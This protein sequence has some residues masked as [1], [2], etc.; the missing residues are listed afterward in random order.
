[1]LLKLGVEGLGVALRNG[2]AERLFRKVSAF[3]KVA[4]NANAYHYGRA[5]VR[6]CLRADVHNVVN[7]LFARN[8]WG[9]HFKLR[10]ILAAKAFRRTDYLHALA[11]NYSYVQ[12]RGGVVARIHAL[13]R[14]GNYRFS[15]QTVS[16][17]RRNAC[18]Y[19]FF[20]VAADEVHVLTYLHK[21]NSHARV[22]TDGQSFLLSRFQIIE[23]VVENALS[24]GRLFRRR[25]ALYALAH[26]LRQHAVCFNAKLF[27][28]LRYY[29]YIYLSHYIIFNPFLQ[30]P[31]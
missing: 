3:F 16:V 26:I 10:H 13:Q 29:A 25:A 4:A 19:S 14:V 6:A 12:H 27:Y 8:G 15:Q 24:Y 22:L 31:F 28:R 1:M 11:S 23:N 9:H 5:G 7:Y 20:K 21:N 30:I 18:V 17:A 2:A